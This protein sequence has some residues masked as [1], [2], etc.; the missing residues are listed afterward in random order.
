MAASSS[1]ASSYDGNKFIFDMPMVKLTFVIVL[2]FWYTYM[3]PGN[4]VPVRG[5]R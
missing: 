3:Y 4:C 5:C 1:L 2:N